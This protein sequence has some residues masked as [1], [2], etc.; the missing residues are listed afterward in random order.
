PEQVRRFRATMTFTLPAAAE[1]QATPVAVALEQDPRQLFPLDEED[2]VGAGQQSVADRATPDL[3]REA[4]KVRHHERRHVTALIPQGEQAL[5]GIA[6]DREHDPSR[7]ERKL[8]AALAK[9]P[10]HLVGRRLPD[11]DAL[12]RVARRINGTGS[13]VE[14]DQAKQR[15]R[16]LGE[17]WRHH[18][19][20]VRT[21][22]TELS[23]ELLE[24]GE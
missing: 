6:H 12:G 19:R 4:P 10:A 18:I 24:P 3:Q 1:G 17:A 21:T 14:L 22:M 9:C 23:K 5:K 8:A 20:L 13:Y 7:P 15:S 11:E 16:I 2:V